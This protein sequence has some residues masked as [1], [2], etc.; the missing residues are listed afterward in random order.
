MSLRLHPGIS[1]CYATNEDTPPPTMDAEMT[2]RWPDAKGDWSYPM[3]LDAHVFRSEVEGEGGTEGGWGF[4]GRRE[5]LIV[6]VCPSVRLS[7]SLLCFCDCVCVLQHEYIYIY[8]Y[9]HIYIYTYIYTHTH[10]C[11]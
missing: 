8:I 6:S 10:I 11:L 4:E 5:R 1:R 9:I 3:S 7:V 2:W